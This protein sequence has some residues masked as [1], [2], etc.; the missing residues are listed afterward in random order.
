MHDSFAERVTAK[1]AA[2]QSRNIVGRIW[3]REWQLWGSDPR[4]LRDRLGWL[5]IAERMKPSV[6]QLEAFAR[7]AA[8][9]GFRHCLLLGMGGSSLGPEVLFR[10]FGASA[11]M[12]DLLVLDSTD[13]RQI[14]A[15]EGSLDLARTLVVVSSKSGSTIE[16][17]SQLEYFWSRIGKGSHFVAI[18]DPGSALESLAKERGF[19]SVFLGDPE[20]GGRFSVLSNFGMVPA[21][22]LGAPVH[23]ILTEAAAM[24][25]RCR[26]AGRPEENPGLALGV[27]MGVASLEGRDK[28]TL[29]MSRA[30]ESFGVWAEQLVAESTGKHG[31]GILPVEGEPLGPPELYGQDRLFVAYEDSRELRALESAGHPVVRLEV[32]GIGGEFFRWE[33]ATAVAGYVLGVQPFDQPNV[34]EAKDAASRILG[35]E[36]PSVQP[37]PLTEALES[38]K[39]GDYIALNAFLPRNDANAG[40][41]A[42][43]RETLRA[44]YCVAVTAGFGP[45]FLH[46]TGQYHK[47]GPDTGV[48]IELVDPGQVDL[49]VPGRDYTFGELEAAQA[50]GDLDSLARRGRRVARLSLEELESALS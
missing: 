36:S 32:A 48:F 29:V 41:L 38:V 10:T 24:A 14:L 47:G 22:L 25:A 13:P 34:Q 8:A 35:G 19:R 27:A 39:P 37:M 28:L 15:A 45:R 4:E 49:G 16:T 46:S 44:R 43:L 3:E 7:Q 26:E 5:D 50:L 21:A 12:L 6:P 11:G 42:A 23:E 17:S 31:T 20:V 9:D 2:F 33:F 30:L 1:L 18:T 40:R